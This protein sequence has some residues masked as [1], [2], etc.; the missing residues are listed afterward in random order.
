M[1]TTKSALT[2]LPDSY[3]YY[4]SP[5]AFYFSPHRVVIGN[6]YSH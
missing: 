5:I 4:F 3:C 2:K 6:Q 1:L